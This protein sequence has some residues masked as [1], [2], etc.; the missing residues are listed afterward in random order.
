MSVLTPVRMPKWGLS[1]QEG[2]VV[3]WIKPE[4]SPVKEGDDLVDI[5]TSKITNVCESPAA[6]ILRKII[7][8]PGETLPVGGL[9]AVLAEADVPESEVDAFITEF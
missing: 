3:E 2:A 9:L 1:M 5:E 7:A 8:Q 6:G 4:G